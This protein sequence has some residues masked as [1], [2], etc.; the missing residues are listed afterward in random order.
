MRAD[1]A[2]IGAGMAGASLAAAIGDRARV[3]VIEAEAHPG[4]HATGRSAAFWSETYGGPHV[5]PL[6]RASYAALVGGGFLRPRGE[7]HIA[8]AASHAALDALA[9]TFADSGVTL[10][11]LD[12]ADLEAM[13][14]GLAPA[15]DRGMAEPTC[16]DIDVGG[17]HADALARLRHAGIM[18]LTDARVTAI[19]RAG[20]N[21]R[22]ETLGGAVTA[23][24]VVNAAGAWASPVA[25]LAGAQPIAITPY[26]RTMVQLALDPPAPAELPLVMDA[27]GRFYFKPE[28]GGRLWVSPHDE[29]PTLAHDVAPEELDVAITIDRLQQVVDWRVLKRER[30]WAGLRSFAPDRLP[31]YG[32]DRHAPGFFWFAGQGGFGIQT[33]PAA[34]AIGAAL[35]LGTSLPET[36]AAIDV[37]RYAP[38]RF[39]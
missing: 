32:F 5:E 24:I 16:R 2:I 14:P 37:A 39:G 13:I 34:A 10:Q 23:P 12:R 25:A 28:A 17:L 3:V 31:V 4:Y 8:D 15:Y 18:L 19:E 6:T 9:A 11:P 38:A 22:V 36:V 1:I 27:A 33:A 26:R 35:L 7:V 20:A 30:A 21:W 29:T